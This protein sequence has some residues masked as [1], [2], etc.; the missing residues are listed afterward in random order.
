MKLIDLDYSDYLDLD[1]AANY[2]QLV[3]DDS[4][5]KTKKS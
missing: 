5:S 2:I 3:G 1:G 4:I